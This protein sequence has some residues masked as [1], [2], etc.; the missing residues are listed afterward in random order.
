MKRLANFLVNKS[1]LALFG[2]ISLILISSFW[3]FQS[4]GQLKAGGYENP[5]SDSTKV[6]DILAD[7]YEESTPEVVIVVDFADG[8]DAEA[9]ATSTNNLVAELKQISGVDGVDSYYSL[10]RPASLISDDGKATYV[11][12]DLDDDITQAPV[13]ADIAEKFSGTYETAEV[14]VAGFATVTA[15][16]NSVIEHDLARTE[17]IAVPLTIVLLVF[18]FGSLM[19]SGL[20]LLVGGLA[21]VGSFFFV[22]ISTQVTDT[23]I[24]ALNLIT[25]LGLGLG[26]DYALLMVNRFREE[27][28]AGKSVSD[29]TVRTVESAGRTVLFSGLTVAIVLAS[30]FFF[31]QYFLKSFALGGVVVVLLSVAA[32]LIAL[33]AML[34]L[35]G[36]RVN[37]WRIIKRDLTPKESGAWGNIAR[38]VM[39]RPVAVMLVA[40][41]GLG[42]LA[43]LSVNAEFGQVDDRI[44]PQSEPA[45]IASNVIRDRFTAK[46]GSP[47]EIV[48]EGASEAQVEEYILNL[49]ELDHIVSVRSSVGFAAEG[50]LLP[51]F[52]PGIDSYSNGDYQRV[53]AIHD[54]DSRSSAGVDLTDEMRALDTSGYDVMVG[55]SAA[56]YTDSQRGIEE[57]LPTAL[58]WIVGWTLVLLFL[59]TGSV[60]LPIKAVLLNMLSLG[61]TIGFITWG[62]LDGSIRWLVGDFYVTGNIDT[63]ST[64]LI[65][66]VAFGLSMDYELFLLS[67]IKEQHD[68]GASTEDS[69]ANGL[70]RSGRIITAAALVLAF[71]FGA[72]ATSG[73]TIMK[74]LGLGIAFA[75]LV[76]ATIVRALLVPAL[77]K[78]FGKA[79]WW[80][81]K[82]MK[83]IYKK[84]GLDH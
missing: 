50:Q 15:S 55:G 76:D 19:A 7:T 36:D 20:P 59:F 69:V 72:F 26:I 51:Q 64:V 43:S 29:A 75:I 40:T 9:S 31:P 74:A 45:A 46:E 65:A 22:W 28:A 78:L 63:S 61:A 77:M 56:I 70:Q 67:R 49:S 4:F 12:V 30:L 62:F 23:S 33:P 47:I 25:G 13:A 16:I 5:Y 27:R 24:F 21:I 81:P 68:A 35:M 66:V 80:A 34:N 17:A 18:V 57:Q 48:L 83:A 54:I 1:K 37:K 58:L 73:V 79:N 60:L 52:G 6:A 8:V 32:A 2:F 71:S 14:Y 84:V 10:G 44:L 3:G 38:F 39:K 53:V 41:L 42:G 82:W 11:F